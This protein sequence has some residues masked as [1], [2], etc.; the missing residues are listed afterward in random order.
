MSQHRSGSA[1]SGAP[2][3]AWPP[4]WWGLA[5]CEADACASVMD[6]CHAA[7]LAM[8]AKASVILSSRKR[9]PFMTVEG[10]LECTEY[11]PPRNR[12]S[13]LFTIAGQ[14]LASFRA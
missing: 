14:V 5:L 4:W 9:G 6:G 1:R 7:T 12:P 13:S 2:G 3:G 8:R 10:L 11:S